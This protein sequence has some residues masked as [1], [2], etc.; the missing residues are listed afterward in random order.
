MLTRTGIPAI[1]GVVTRALTQKRV[2]CSPSCSYSPY[3]HQHLQFPWRLSGLVPSCLP[4]HHHLPT[5]DQPAPILQHRTESSPW[6]ILALDVEM[7]FNRI[8]CSLRRGVKV[9]LAV[10]WDQFL[11]PLRWETRLFCTLYTPR[12][13]RSQALRSKIL[14]ILPSMHPTIKS[15]GQTSAIHSQPATQPLAVMS[16]KPTP[17]M[18]IQPVNPRTTRMTVRWE[19]PWPRKNLQSW[20]SHYCIY[21]KTW[22]SQRSPWSSTRSS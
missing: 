10:P 14:T 12:A 2:W 19:F 7:K 15:V 8:R 3:H 1:Y 21:N 17:L 6:R 16:L 13:R 9:L 5:C 18:P 4:V 20:N 11:K 22:K